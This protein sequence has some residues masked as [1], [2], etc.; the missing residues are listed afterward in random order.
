MGNRSKN[1]DRES[2][3]MGFVLVGEIGRVDPC[4]ALHFGQSFS[5]NLEL[6]E[7][8]RQNKNIEN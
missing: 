5:R 6:G 7:C 2:L 3:K 1:C 4:G 8:L